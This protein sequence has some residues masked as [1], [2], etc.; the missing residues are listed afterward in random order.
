[1]GEFIGAY[2]ELSSF[3]ALKTLNNSPFNHLITDFISESNLQPNTPTTI[4]QSLVDVDN[5]IAN[6]LSTC[7]DFELLSDNTKKTL[8]YIY[9]Y[10]FLPIFLSCCAV[11]IMENAD[12]VR[13]KF[14]EVTT[15]AEVRS[16][17]R[18]P[19]S[20]GFDQTLLK[21]FRV[22]TG[23]DVNFREEPNMKSN[24]ITRLPIGTLVEIIDKSNRSWLLVE[25]KIDGELEQGWISRSHTTY[26]K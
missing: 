14:L 5:E 25:I 6:E 8:L 7:S 24:V 11:I 22:T 21:G 4:S 23:H 12:I 3:N 15:A 17:V 20:G 26:F 18:S 2:S 10:Y 19:S 9:H 1:M 13:S 16:L